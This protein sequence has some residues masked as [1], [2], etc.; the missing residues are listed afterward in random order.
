[1]SGMAQIGGRQP[2]PVKA[3]EGKSY[4]WCRVVQSP[5]ILRRLS[6]NDEVCSR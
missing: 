2:I 1:M 4:W 3:E 6:Q 5:A